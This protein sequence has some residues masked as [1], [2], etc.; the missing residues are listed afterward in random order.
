MKRKCDN[1]PFAT[2]GKGLHLRKSLRPG[3]WREIIR[4]IYLGQPFYCHKTV[5]WDAQGEDSDDYR[6][7]GNEQV[8][9]GSIEYLRKVRQ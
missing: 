7:T 8:C 9:H 1:C 6:P 3:R 5:D 4:S 2:R